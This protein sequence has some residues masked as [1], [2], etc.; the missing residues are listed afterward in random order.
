MP[1]KLEDHIRRMNLS[2]KYA[3][4]KP[5]RRLPKTPTS[6]KRRSVIDKINFFNSKARR[7][8]P[9]GRR[10]SSVRRMGSRKKSRGKKKKLTIAQRRRMGLSRSGTKCKRGVTKSGRCRKKMKSGARS[11][12]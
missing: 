10:Q 5:R 11:R 2:N 12:R 1:S 4:R 7:R 3:A 8:T 6:T 9:R